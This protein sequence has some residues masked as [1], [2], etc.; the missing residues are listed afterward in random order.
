MTLAKQIATVAITLQ[1]SFIYRSSLMYS[2]EDANSRRPSAGRAR[3]TYHPRPHCDRPVS[4]QPGMRGPPAVN[5][6]PYTSASI[7]N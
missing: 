6:A 2:E 1:L 3:T 4:V 5:F 7:R